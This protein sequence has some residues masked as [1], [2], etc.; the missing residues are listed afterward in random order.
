MSGVRR[1]LGL[2]DWLVAACL[3]WRK[4]DNRLALFAAVSL[5]TFPIAFNDDFISTL[6]SSWWFPAHFISF[7][8]SVCIVL[9]FYVFPGGHFVPRW[10]GWVLVPLLAYWGS[11]NSSL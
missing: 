1:M 10:T 7:L 8:G 3:F 11:L 5:G 2:G 6:S 4:S 9:F